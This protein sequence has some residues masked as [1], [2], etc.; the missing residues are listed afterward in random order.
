M[1]HIKINKSL[2]LVFHKKNNSKGEYK[3]SN[4]K[5]Y[6]PF[7]Y[8]KFDIGIYLLFPL[9]IGVYIGYNVDL[10]LKTRPT[11]TIF[12]LVLGTLSSFYNLWKLTKE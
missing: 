2:D 11:F 5:K 1:S 9:L 12:F 6:N 7:Q 8:F 10:R 3:S 4:K